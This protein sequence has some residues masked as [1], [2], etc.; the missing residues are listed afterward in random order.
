ME[1][2]DSVHQILQS[3]EM[4]ADRFYQHYLHRYPE[5]RRYFAGMDLKRQ[6]VQLH[7]ALLLAAHHYVHRYPA[8]TSYLRVLG[9]THSARRGVPAELYDGFRDCLLETLAQFH[10]DQWD[11]QLALQW[12]EALDLAIATMLEGYDGHHSV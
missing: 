5:V 2:Q 12:R 10:A 9:H 7:M 1:I 11:D 6:A 4:V 8:T 3:S